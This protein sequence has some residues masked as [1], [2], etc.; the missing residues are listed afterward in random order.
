MQEIDAANKKQ[1]GG[2]LGDGKD[3]RDFDDHNVFSYVY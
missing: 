3:K 1:A 2:K